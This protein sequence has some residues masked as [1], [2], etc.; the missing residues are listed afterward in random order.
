M[1]PVYIE[2]EWLSGKEKNK[3][4]KGSQPSMEDYVSN[5]SKCLQDLLF[6]IVRSEVVNVRTILFERRVKEMCITWQLV[7]VTGCY[8]LRSLL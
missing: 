5:N 4:I 8:C 2:A 6:K 1:L 7:G 3:Q